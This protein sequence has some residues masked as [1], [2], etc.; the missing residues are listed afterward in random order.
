MNL[1]TA[2][3]DRYR[4]DRSVQALADHWIFSNIKPG[5]H[6]LQDPP[7]LA[8]DQICELYEMVSSSLKDF[9]PLNLAIWEAFFGVYK[10]MP[11]DM[12]IYLIVGAP[13]PYDAFVRFHDGK[14]AAIFDL[15]R[16]S[17]YSQ[18][19]AD[20]VSIVRNLITHEFSH[21]RIHENHLE[22][23]HDAPIEQVL[24]HILFNE[25]IAHF[26][27]YDRDVS[28]V[29]WDT[30]DLLEKKRKAYSSLRHEFSTCSASNRE[31]VLI[32]ATSGKFWDKFAAVSG[33]FAVADYYVQH[34]KNLESLTQLYLQGPDLLW[35]FWE[36]SS[37]ALPS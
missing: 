36:E 12:I 27:A 26:L 19:P 11:D 17:T 37:S 2:I 8:Y 18:N 25:G 29:D 5:C 13:E 30:E 4:E 16:F 7:E 20:L 10:G 24:R 1:D 15:Y 14:N 35:D 28:S 33:L 23:P 6:L 31:D 3:A 9:E 34:Q 32:R 21:I 22:P